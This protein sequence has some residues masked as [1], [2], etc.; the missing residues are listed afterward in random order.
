[1]QRTA[2]PYECGRK[3]RLEVQ[4][5]PSKYNC[6]LDRMGLIVLDD[7]NHGFIS[8]AEAAKMERKVFIGPSNIFV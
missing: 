1:M 7:G 3:F 8:C 4:L 6:L 5:A 2:N